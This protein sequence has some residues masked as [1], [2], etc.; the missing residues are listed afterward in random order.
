MESE[1]REMAEGR[2][3]RS[4]QNCGGLSQGKSCR[5]E[6][7][8]GRHLVETSLV[9]SLLGELELISLPDALRTRRSQP[10]QLTPTILKVYCEFIAWAAR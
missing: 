4:A 10:W 5:P 9:N 7:P 6:A 3:G 8:L 2:G 1:G